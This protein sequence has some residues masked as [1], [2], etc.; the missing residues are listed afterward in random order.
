MPANLRLQ[1]SLSAMATPN[2]QFD[3]DQIQRARSREDRAATAS[4]VDLD[5]GIV[6]NSK[7]EEELSRAHRM[8]R[9]FSRTK[10]MGRWSSRSRSR[11]GTR[12]H[13]DDD[14]EYTGLRKPGDYKTKQ[15][16]KGRRLFFLAYQSIGVI[17]GDIGTSPLYVYSST[18]VELHPTKQNVRASL[19]NQSTRRLMRSLIHSLSESSH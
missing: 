9:F 18:F 10:S 7:V 1:A 15:V 5:H 19:C 6:S 2:I 14:P 4:G 16:F 17:Y 13:D 12:L 11:T 8:R 3:D